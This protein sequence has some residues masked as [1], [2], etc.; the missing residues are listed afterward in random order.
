MITTMR[1]VRVSTMLLWAA[2]LAFASFLAAGFRPVHAAAP[3]YEGKTIRIIVGTS[4]GGGYDTYTRLIARHFAKHIPGVPS[5]IVDNMPG[6][7]GLVSANHLF[8]VAKPDGLTIGHF[9][10]GQF[11]QQLLGRPGIE[12]D[13]L[14]FEY[15][16]VPAQDNFVFGIAKTTGITSIEQLLAAK[17]PVKFGAIAV[18]DGTYDTAKVAEV[19]LHLPIQVVS[20]YK[21]TAPIR[22]AFNSGEVGGLSNSWQSF[23]STWRKEIDNGEMSVVLQLSAKP[24]PDLAKVPLAVNL[25]KTDDAR[26]L[27][28]AVAQAHGAAV[29]P[30]VLPPGTP[31]DR[32]EILRKA[33]L[34]TVK[35]PELLNEAGK[36]NLEFNPGSGEELE[37]NVRDLLRLEPALVARLKDILK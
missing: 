6:A 28:Q 9:V 21:G 34:E 33:F 20:G 10:G 13:A 1:Q 27:I 37:R 31:K 30:Y 36:A 32:V 26:K 8:K 18:G 4:P 12:F 29:R 2:A 23:R 17:T 24:H 7:G 15:I 35:D 25:A 16:G 11:L 5:I 3:F 22:L 19:T 14:K